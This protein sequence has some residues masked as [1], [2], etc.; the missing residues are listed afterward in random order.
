MDSTVIGSPRYHAVESVHLTNQVA[1][2]QTPDRGI[3][4][5][6]TDLVRV[7]RDECHR[8]AQSSTSTR[9]LDPG[10]AAANHN[11]LVFAGHCQCST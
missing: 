5:H 1:L 8:R 9:G 6:R 2:T 10:M 3:A 4:T 7:E 11:H